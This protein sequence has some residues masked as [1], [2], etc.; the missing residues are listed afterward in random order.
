MVVTPMGGLKLTKVHKR[1][2]RFPNSALHVDTRLQSI[3]I[4][5]SLHL[6]SPSERERGQVSQRS[7]CGVDCVCFDLTLRW[8]A[9]R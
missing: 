8:S 3:T 6:S 9:R 5:S 7:F 2:R 4:Y 1:Y